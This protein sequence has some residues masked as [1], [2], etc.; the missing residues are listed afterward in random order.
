MLA[1]SVA[2]AVELEIDRHD[3]KM[4]VTDTALR[5]D[6]TGKGGNIVRW[7]AQD[8]RLQTIVVIEMQMQR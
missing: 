6:R 3:P 4:T 1:E 5:R 7:P 8:G 2:M